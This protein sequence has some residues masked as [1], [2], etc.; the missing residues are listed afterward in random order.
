MIGPVDDWDEAHEGK[1]EGE[2]RAPTGTKTVG[3]YDVRGQPA[4]FRQEESDRYRGVIGAAMERAGWAMRSGGA[5]ILSRFFQM[6]GG[7]VSE[8]GTVPAA[9]QSPAETGQRALLDGMGR[10][11]VRLA[12]DV[13]NWVSERN[14]IVGE[15]SRG[16]PLQGFRT[17]KEVS[18]GLTL[19]S[20]LT[21]SLYNIAYASL[22][23]T[24]PMEI[25]RAKHQTVRV[26]YTPGVTGERVIL[27]PQITQGEVPEAWSFLP[28]YAA[29]AVPFAGPTNPPTFVQENVGHF[30]LDPF[31]AFGASL[32]AATPVTATF[33]IGEAYP[34]RLPACKSLRFVAR[35]TSAVTAGTIVVWATQE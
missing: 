12:G 11:W 16:V 5:A 15:D 18:A 32:V 29:A 10:W 33:V 25:D 31:K 30:A 7:V 19:A 3:G 13:N 9:N 20:A 6:A 17:I 27:Y 1:P 26:V 23:A 8:D 14:A 28:T 21:A 22:V 35:D 24:L 2:G 34:H 4:V